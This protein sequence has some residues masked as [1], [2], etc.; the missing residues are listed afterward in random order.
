MKLIFFQ[1]HMPTT[2]DGG[3]FPQGTY[4]LGNVPEL[5]LS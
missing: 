2:A 5:T 4:I 1:K 3:S